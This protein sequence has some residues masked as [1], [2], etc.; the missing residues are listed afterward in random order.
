MF[1]NVASQTIDV[2]AFDYS[3]GAPKTGDAAN[4]SVYL[5]KDD[6]SLPQLTDTSATEISSTNAPGW[7]R[8][9]VSQTE[10][11]ADKLLFTGKSSTSN[12][13]VVCGPARYT[14]PAGFGDLT[15]ANN[16]TAANVTRWSGT[17]V[18]SPD[19]A[20]YPKV[21]VKS[22][23]GTGELNLSSGVADGNVTKVGGVAVHSA[24]ARLEVNATHWAGKSVETSNDTPLVVTPAQSHVNA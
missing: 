11:N 9:D 18:A 14:R 7:Y 20:G 5:S 8:F 22:G 10:S 15:I 4:I 21:T 19:T 16:A 6:G 3:T 13:T 23:T 12:V 24:N 2:F 1:K 17:A